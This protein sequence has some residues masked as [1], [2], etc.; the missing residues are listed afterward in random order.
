MVVTKTRTGNIESLLPIA[1]VQLHCRVDSDDDITVLSA[2]R[3][4]AVDSVEHSTRRT[5]LKSEYTLSMSDFTNVILP[6]PPVDLDK[7]K[8]LYLEKDTTEYKELDAA[9]YQ[10]VESEKETQILF[11]FE[12]LD[13]QLEDVTNAVKVEYEAGYTTLPENLKAAML[14]LISHWYDNPNAASPESLK[15]IPLGVTWLMQQKSVYR[16]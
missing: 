3:G 10:V 16:F 1:T 4:A 12:L 14:L 5:L 6:H 9:D 8:V 13:I 2:L 15:E 11:D 7:I